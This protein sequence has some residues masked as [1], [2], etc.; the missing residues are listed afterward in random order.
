[1]RCAFA[2]AALTA[3]QG[4]DVPLNLTR[5]RFLGQAGLGIGAAALA[6]LLQLDL[7]AQSADPI[8]SAADSLAGLPH[9]APKA[10][11]V[12][13]LFQSGAPSQLDLFDY[14]P[15]LAKTHGT[16]RPDSI[17]NGQRLTAMTAGQTS[18]PVDAANCLLARRLAE[19]GVRFIQ[20]YHRAWIIIRGRSRSGWREAASSRGS[21]SA[22]RT[23][24]ATTSR[25]TRCTF[26]I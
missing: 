23:T 21:R 7:L 3:A 24:T 1:V 8:A 2:L 22:K 19:R 10:K 20:L 16:D 14:K 17:R 5:R 15:Q 9:F 11:R 26:T 25:R 12:I 18:F 6:E 4:I 13:Y